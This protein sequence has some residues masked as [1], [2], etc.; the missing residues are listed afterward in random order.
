MQ[1]KK[2]N[3]KTLDII[4]IQK[5]TQNEPWINIKY[6]SMKLSNETISKNLRDLVLGD[7]LL[8]NIKWSIKKLL[9]ELDF[10]KSNTFVLGK[11]V[12]RMN[13]EATHTGRKHVEII[14]PADDLHPYF[15][16]YGKNS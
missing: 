13:H 9:I 11:T 1:K 16:E 5:L 4:F 8:D 2:K 3:K 6:T 15:P 7:N 14:Y 10:M 12:K